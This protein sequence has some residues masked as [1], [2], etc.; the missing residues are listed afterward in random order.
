M[1]VTPALLWM[2]LFFVAPFVAMALLSLNFQA[3]GGMTVANYSQFFTNPSYYR[4]MVNS[5]PFAGSSN[6]PANT[7]FTL[8]SGAAA[9]APCS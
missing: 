3:E 4:A 1:L 8:T 2:L 9:L 7:E 5:L 6:V